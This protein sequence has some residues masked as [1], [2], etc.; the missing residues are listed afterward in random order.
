MNKWNWIA[1]FLQSKGN[2]TSCYRAGQI[3][4]AHPHKERIDE[5]VAFDIDVFGG[6]Q[7]D[8]SL[9]DH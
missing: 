1:K 7:T 5:I 6:V 4:R 8:S 2:K 9:S 3:I